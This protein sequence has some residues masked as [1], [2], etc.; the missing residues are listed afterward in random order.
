MCPELPA[1]ESNLGNKPES[2]QLPARLPG[3]YQDDWS[4]TVFVDSINVV[5]QQSNLK[6]PM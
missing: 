3:V 1:G 4:T 2:S 6:S 5:R